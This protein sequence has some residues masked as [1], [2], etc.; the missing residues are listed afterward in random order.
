MGEVTSSREGEQERQNKAKGS[1]K[2]VGLSAM[3]ETHTVNLDR[4]FFSRFF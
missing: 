2:P 1:K 3:N 4:F